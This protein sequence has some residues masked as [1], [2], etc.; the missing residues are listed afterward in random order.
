MAEMINI[1]EEQ[2]L[3]GFVGKLIGMNNTFP[4]CFVMPE[5]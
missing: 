3:A 4:A 2:S 5:I 1:D